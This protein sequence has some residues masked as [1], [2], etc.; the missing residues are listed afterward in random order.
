[1]NHNEI[2]S[3]VIHAK[4]GSK[5]ELLKLLEQYKPFIFKTAKEFKIRNYDLYDLLQIGYIAL[6][7][8]VTK[9]KTGSNTFSTYAYTAIKNAFRYTARQNSKFDDHFSLN[10]RVDSSESTSTEYIDCLESL[11]NL[12]EDIL[13]SEKLMEVR[14]AVARLPAEDMALVI[15]VYF[16]G[17]SL[18]TYAEKKGMDYQKAVRKRNRILVKLDHYIKR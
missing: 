13:H 1:M 16:N 11:E 15:M 8:S 7:N 3:C 6:I 5:D 4:K 10:C 12:E 2:E 18:R 17:V 14:K 9:Y